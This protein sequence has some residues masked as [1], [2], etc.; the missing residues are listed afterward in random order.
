MKIAISIV[1]FDSPKEILKKNIYMLSK[2]CF[3]NNKSNKIEI[4]F[5]DNKNGNQIKLVSEICSNY[6]NLKSKFI[7]GENVGFGSAHNKI[8]NSL[9]DEKFDYF[10]IMN[11]DGIAHPNII[12]NLVNL[13]VL[14]NNNGIF[15]ALQFPVQHPK[16]YEKNSKETDWC[17]GCCCLF[18]Y[19]I[20]KKLNGFDEAFF[21]YMEDVDISWRARNLGIKCYTAD[22]ALFF[23]SSDGRVY[24]ENQEIMILKSAYLLA[25]K[26][27]HEKFAS[28]MEKKLR[29]LLNQSDFQGFYSKIKSNPVVVDG[30]FSKIVNFNNDL[31]FSE[32]RW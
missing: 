17:S 8:F 25:K 7:F 16:I 15:E 13:A 20:F 12:T 32:A 10:L 28:K 29:K 5:C 4:F 24:N 11:P 9:I 31:Y 18:P 21:M 2:Q 30:N 3:L 27:C 6:P 26:Y 19:K 22:D 14:K 1:L 23:H